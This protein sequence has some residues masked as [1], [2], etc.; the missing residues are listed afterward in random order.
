MDNYNK[1]SFAQPSRVSP[2]VLYLSQ[3]PINP[4]FII[5]NLITLPPFPRQTWEEVENMI[6]AACFVTLIHCTAW[7]NIFPLKPPSPTPPPTFT[8]L[9]S[10]TIHNTD[11]L[12]PNVSLH[13]VT[14]RV[15][16]ENDEY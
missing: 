9:S 16:V 14:T 2:L 11:H 12:H 3:T 7:E 13:V 10:N 1:W 6:T 15:E 8:N 5:P 4:L